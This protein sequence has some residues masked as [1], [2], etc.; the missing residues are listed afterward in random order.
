ME[1]Y[2][3]VSHHVV[4]FAGINEIVGLGA[5]VNAGT[6]ESEVVLQDAGRVVVTDDNLQTALEVLGLVEE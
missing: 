5:G 1:V 4:T 6:E 2:H 3:V